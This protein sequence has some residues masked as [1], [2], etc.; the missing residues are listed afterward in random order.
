MIITKLILKI[1]MLVI[2]TYNFVSLRGK[3]SR[4]LVGGMTPGRVKRLERYQVYG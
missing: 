3:L 2:S 1:Y 4:Q